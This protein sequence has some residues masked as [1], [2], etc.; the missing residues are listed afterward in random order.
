MIKK[1]TIPNADVLTWPSN[2]IEL[3]PAPGINKFIQPLSAIFTIENYIADW[4]NISANSIIEIAQNTSD[5]NEL[6]IRAL[7]TAD[8]QVQ[9]ILA[10]GGNF[11]VLFPMQFGL[12]GGFPSPGSTFSVQSSVN[13]ALFMALNNGVSGNLT[14]GDPAQS[15]VV[16]LTYVVHTR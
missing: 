13:E 10:P 6:L 1:V 8:N 15:L 16:Y 2:N 12:A 11:N 5:F 7:N 14:G 3:L 9:R 4:T